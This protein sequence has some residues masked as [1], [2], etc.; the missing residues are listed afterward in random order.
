MEWYAMIVIIEQNPKATIAFLCQLII[1]MIQLN[2]KRLENL[3]RPPNESSSML[4]LMCFVRVHWTF[5]R[6][7]NKYL[8][9]IDAR[10]HGYTR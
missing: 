4:Q 9:V 10:K 5:F 7:L 3:S 6:T 1:M 8:L 2:W